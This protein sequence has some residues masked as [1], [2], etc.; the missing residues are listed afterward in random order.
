MKSLLEEHDIYPRRYFYPSLHTLPYVKASH[1]PISEQVAS[2]VLCLPLYDSLQENE[3]KQII[4]L[5]I[6]GL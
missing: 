4:D 5:I 6:K 1:Y 3:Q 2:S